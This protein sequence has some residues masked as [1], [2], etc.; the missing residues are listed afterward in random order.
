MALCQ[1]A[2]VPFVWKTFLQND[3]HQPFYAEFLQSG[4]SQQSSSRV[5]VVERLAAPSSQSEPSS[6]GSASRHL[7][8]QQL[9]LGL[10]STWTGG[11]VDPDMPLTQAGLD[12]LGPPAPPTPQLACQR[13]STSLTQSDARRP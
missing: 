11:P 8:L 6:I 5:S 13:A 9:V 2:A 12:S 1:V 10:I 7:E 4:A 3:V